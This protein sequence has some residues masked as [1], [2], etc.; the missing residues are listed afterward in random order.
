MPA[1]HLV[2]YLLAQICDGMRTAQRQA[3]AVRVLTAVTGCRLTVTAL[4]QS[5]AQK[6]KEKHSLKRTDRL[7]SH[8]HLHNGALA[9]RP[10]SASGSPKPVRQRLPLLQ[11]A[12]EPGPGD[13]F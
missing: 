4:G 5:I 10:F 13:A 7:L 2:H 12:G 11:G 9:R 6:A 1:K 3:L 8:R